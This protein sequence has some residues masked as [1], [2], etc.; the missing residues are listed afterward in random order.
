MSSLKYLRIVIAAF[1]F[2][3]ITALFL[4][5][6]ETVPTSLHWFVHVQIVPAGLLGGGVGLAI[7]AAW[8]VVTVQTGRIYCSAVCPFGIL[9]DIISGIVKPFRGKKARFRFRSEMTA[10]RYLFLAAFVFALLGFPAVVALLEPYS[11]FGRIAHSLL[12]PL[13]LAGNNLL[14]GIFGDQAFYYQPIQVDYS[15]I[16]V[17]LTALI[18]A[19]GLAAFFGRR[20]CN[21]LCPVGTFLGLLSRCSVFKI[22]LKNDCVSCGLCEKACKGECIDSK[23]KTI[24]SSRC[25]ACF[26][27]LSTCK[28]K[29]IVYERACP[30]RVRREMSAPEEAK[31][32]AQRRN[33]LRFSLVSFV[34]PALTG[35]TRAARSSASLADPSLPTG[36]SRV[37]YEMTAPIL[38][39]GASDRNHFQA[40]CTACHLCVS[41]CPA[42]IIR[43]SVTELGLSGFLQPVVKFEDGF[44]NYDCTI[45]TEVCPTH[46]LIPI[47]TKEEKHRLQIGRVV[48]LKENCVVETQGSNCGA[49]A[50]HCPTGAVAMV[51]Y[52]KPEQALT[53]PV[54]DA[55]LCIGCG[56]CERI[57]PVRPYR[58]I[59]VDGLEKH[60][61]AKPAYDPNAKQQEV[62]MDDF[63]F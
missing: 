37:E 17:A 22:R 18:V 6:T 12:R 40:K 1:F 16:F 27:C 26:N 30:S 50:E 14:A 38:P 63:G 2:V 23:N 62:Q 3:A 31:T 11:H 7:V 44:C 46:A 60:A 55:D 54:I 34:V 58:A 51:P 25:V 48:F 47:K 15:A 49:C 43:P 20:Y 36:V 59:Y 10:V 61:Q 21:T 33:F 57:C 9:Q 39:P 28:Q 13:Y 35:T 42:G 56:A 24:D 53:I 29:A 52:G 32:D 19:G 41:K 45:C 4:D 8:I 5:F